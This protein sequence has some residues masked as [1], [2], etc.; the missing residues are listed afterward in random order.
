MAFPE[1]PRRLTLLAAALL[2]C[3]PARVRSAQGGRGNALV[4]REVLAVDSRGQLSG[5]AAQGGTTAGLEEKQAW[6][7]GRPTASVSSRS[8]ARQKSGPTSRPQRA[9]GGSMQRAGGE[10]G[11]GNE[12]GP[13][14]EAKA[15]VQVPPECQS[16]LKHIDKLADYGSRITLKECIKALAASA[17][18]A[19]NS[20][21]VVRHELKDVKRRER[22]AIKDTEKAEKEM[23]VAQ[24]LKDKALVEKS[25][26]MHLSKQ[27]KM[28]IYI[29]I[30]IC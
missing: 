11:V 17:H 23:K 27:V 29:Y 24:Q 22:Q 25:C 2:L 10:E 20:E 12:E 14:L 4:R 8:G 28:D 15:Q 9:L 30:Y 5:G 1:R 21:T 26:T 7:G 6:T 18:I 13:A 3:P 16:L 19:N